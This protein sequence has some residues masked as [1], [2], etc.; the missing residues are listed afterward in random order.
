M[1]VLIITKSD[2]NESVETVSRALVERGARP[3]RFD[4][5]RFPTDVRLALRYGDPR[6]TSSLASGGDAIDLGEIDSVWYR[7][8]D[9]GARIPTNVEK[10]MRGPCIA[11]SRA[12][13]FGMI[14]CLD[15]FQMN[16]PGRVRVADQKPL[17]LRLAEHL[18]L[19]VPKTLITNDPE[20]VREFA[21]GCP[22]GF[23][24][25]MLSSFAIGEGDEERVVFTN[26]VKPEDLDDLDGLRL[27]PM[28][29]QEEIAKKLEIRVTIVG[30][31]CFAAAVD[32]QALD[33]AQIDWR[34]EG[35]A[36][37]DA[38]KPY[39]LP[40]DVESRLGRL[41]DRL[42]LDYGAIDLILTPDGRHVFLEINPAGEFFWL[43]GGAGLP[44][45]AAI[46]DTLVD[47]SHRRR[48]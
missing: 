48:R 1:N 45:S 40:P 34:R 32:S 10:S 12:T 15:V 9:V 42:R 39:V 8:V 33:R 11:E 27:S 20:R 23:V 21:R 2:D 38:W 19:V 26:R 28:T 18:G 41:M 46:A 37:V 24:A 5:D 13:V 14:A 16:S 31:R 29:F 17:Q 30:D 6:L 7:R 25:K 47:P 4:T 3:I 22:N 35:S 43:E 44:L 36:L